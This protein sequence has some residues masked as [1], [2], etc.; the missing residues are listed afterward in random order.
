MQFSADSAGTVS[1]QKHS[2][3]GYLAGLVA[4]IAYGSNPLFGKD[5][6]S[7]GVPVISILFFR[8][9][10][11]TLCIALLIFRKRESVRITWKQ[12][13]WMMM[14]GLFFSASSLTL[15]ESYNYI[16]A[17]LA[18]TVVYLYPVF[19][20]LIMMF[21]HQMPSWQSWVSI[22]ASLAGV[23]IM[24]GIG[25]GGDFNAKGVLLCA[26]S[27]FS[28][29]MYLVIVN[30]SRRLAN[31]SADTITLYSLG[32]G[33]I[34]Y[35][36][37][38]VRSGVPVTRGIDR[39]EDWIDL[40]G[41]GIVPTMIAMLTLAISTKTIGPTKTA[42]LGV[43]EPLTA[44]AIGSLI[45]HEPFTLNVAA[46]VAVCIAAILFMVLSDHKKAASGQQ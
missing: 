24:T 26:A 28:Y 10:I 44:I 12:F 36:F 31:I 45:F 1:R 20:A 5:L 29:S 43:A 35:M 25:Q 39:A 30:Q 15:F 2:S 14:L 3:G 33:T 46:G 22:L 34:L 17:G 37:L 8:Y 23:A 11:A 40:L 9:I 32:I 13:E 41:L 16:P 18:T 7:G 38:S 6:L 27:A 19:T 21:L 4:G 42:V